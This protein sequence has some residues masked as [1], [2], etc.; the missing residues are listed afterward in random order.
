MTAHLRPPIGQTGMYR[1]L[2]QVN[3]QALNPA[4]AASLNNLGNMLS[5]QGRRDEALQAAV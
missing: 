1:Q 2:A 4:L 3:P 5:D